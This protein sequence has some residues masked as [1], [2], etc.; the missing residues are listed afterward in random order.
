MFQIK[1]TKQYAISVTPSVTIVQT[2]TIYIS[3]KGGRY[4]RV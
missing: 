4:D 3:A 2:S 1:H